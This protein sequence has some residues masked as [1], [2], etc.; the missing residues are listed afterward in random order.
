[1]L[2]HTPLHCHSAALTTSLLFLESWVWLRHWRIHHWTFSD[3]WTFFICG[4][5]DQIVASKPPFKHSFSILLASEMCC[6]VQANLSD[7]DNRPADISS[8]FANWASR[9]GL[10]SATKLCFILYTWSNLLLNLDY[11][12]I[13]PSM[14][15]NLYHTYVMHQTFSYTVS[16]SYLK[17]AN[18]F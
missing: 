12:L 6:N 17:C 9:S 2:F 4:I 16:N 10:I 18:I 5:S 7:P 13:F 11:F 3:K 14:P 8:N 1:M 15:S